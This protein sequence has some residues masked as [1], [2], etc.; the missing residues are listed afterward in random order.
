MLAIQKKLLLH[1]RIRTGLLLILAALFLISTVSL[2]K[3][4]SRLQTVSKSASDMISKMDF[5]RLASSADAL[6]KA[7][8]ELE[9]LDVDRFNEAAS[10]FTTASEK[11]SEVDV[12]ELNK[13]MEAF[14]SA[15][16][17]LKDLNIQ[18]LNGLVTSLNHVSET[19]EKTV[20]SIQNL[21]R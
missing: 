7:A 5:E 20:S 9:K 11:L 14:S 10:S 13:A 4:S 16:N 18:E 21:F 1:S 8:K 2:T 17:T 3:T 12:E 15:A 19:L 6:G